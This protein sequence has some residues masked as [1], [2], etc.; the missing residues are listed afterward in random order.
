[1]AK[2]SERIWLVTAGIVIGFV[3]LV[4]VVEMIHSF[5]G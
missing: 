1:M 5:R 3:L 4:V 2:K